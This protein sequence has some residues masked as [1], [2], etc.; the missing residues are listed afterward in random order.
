V[1]AFRIEYLVPVAGYPGGGIKR[2]RKIVSNDAG[3]ATRAFIGST[4]SARIIRV[5]EDNCKN[6]KN[7]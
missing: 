3:T 1:K 7:K 5:Y 2:S 6:C 4:K